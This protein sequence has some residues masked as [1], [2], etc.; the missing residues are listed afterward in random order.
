MAISLP[1]LSGIAPY[2]ASHT[3]DDNNGCLLLIGF[4]FGQPDR[5]VITAAKKTA[6]TEEIVLIFIRELIRLIMLFSGLSSG[7]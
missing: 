4:S 6:E 7:R 2:C 1:S 3:G 5:T